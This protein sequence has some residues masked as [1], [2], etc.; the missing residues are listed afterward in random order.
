MA[1]VNNSS[2]AT[3]IKNM[4]D[5]FPSDNWTITKALGFCCYDGIVDIQDEFILDKYY[6]YLKDFLIEVDV[7][8][9]YYYAPQ[10]FAK[11]YYGDP[12]LDFLVLY[13]AG[14]TTIFE[15]KRPK[16]KVLDYTHLPDINRIFTKY[17]DYITESRENPKVYKSTDISTNKTIHATYTNK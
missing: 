5:L 2:K 15:F 4:I 6:N 12:K 1:I 13:F 10:T 9:K 14:M 7:D 3:T 17:S 11:D 16:I 8:P